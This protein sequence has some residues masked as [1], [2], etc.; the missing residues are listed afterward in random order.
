MSVQQKVLQ[1]TLLAKKAEIRKI[2][3]VLVVAFI[4]QTK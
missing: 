3:F 1:I 4:M 2:Q